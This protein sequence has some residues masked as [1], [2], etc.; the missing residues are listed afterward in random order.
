MT[1]QEKNIKTVILDG[2]ETNVERAIAML[3]IV[4]H[5]MVSVFD[6]EGNIHPEAQNPRAIINA[7]QDLIVSALDCL[8]DQDVQLTDGAKM[9]VEFAAKHTQVYP[10]AK[11]E[12]LSGVTIQ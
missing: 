10:A 7:S 11:P 5:A 1:E 8:C 2:N 9:L 12:D 3:F 6:D 4:H